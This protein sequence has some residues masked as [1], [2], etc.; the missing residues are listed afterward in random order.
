MPA[1]KTASGQVKNY[2]Y[3]PKGVQAAKRAADAGMG[4]LVNTKASG[5]MKSGAYKSLPTPT[6]KAAN[7]AM[8]GAQSY[9]MLDTV[10]KGV[11]APLKKD[12]PVAK[13]LSKYAGAK[14]KLRGAMKSLGYTR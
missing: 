4:K 11:P 7:S 12:A 5:A 2:A 8:K 1:I 10:G 13:T 14:A 3:N 6:K 9:K